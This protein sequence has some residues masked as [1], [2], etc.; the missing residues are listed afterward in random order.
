MKSFQR[1]F[2][3]QFSAVL[4][5]VLFCGMAFVSLSNVSAAGR[6]VLRHTDSLE[7]AKEP[8][9]EKRKEIN[10]K[11]LKAI[12]GTHALYA[13]RVTNSP[14]VDGDIYDEVYKTAP[15]T[16]LSF[17]EERSPGYPRCHTHVYAVCDKENLYLGFECREIRQHLKNRHIE[18]DDPRILKYSFAGVVLDLG[19]RSGPRYFIVLTTPFGQTYTAAAASNARTWDVSWQP[20]GLKAAT[21]HYVDRWLAE[22]CIPLTGDL[23]D[24]PAIIGA[25]YFRKRQCGKPQKAMRYYNYFHAARPLLPAGDD[26]REDEVFPGIPFLNPMIFENAD[27]PFFCPLFLSSGKKDAGLMKRIRTASATLDTQ[28]EY[29]AAHVPD[30]FALSRK[31]LESVFGDPAFLVPRIEKAPRIDGKGDDAA[32][33]KGKGLRLR[34]LLEEVPGVEE[35]NPT[36]VKIVSDKTHLYLYAHCAEE[37][38]DKLHMNPKE[39]MWRHDT[40]E[41]LFDVGHLEDYRNYYHIM[42]NP[43]GKCVLEKDRCDQRWNPESFTLASQINKDSWSVECKIAFKDLGIQTDCFPKLWGANFS[44]TRWVHRPEWNNPAEP[45]WDTAWK[46]NSHTVLHVPDRWGHLYFQAG[47]AVQPR[48]QRVLNEKGLD[49]KT[50]GF[51]PYRFTEPEIKTPR[52]SP[53]RKAAFADRPD[54]SIKGESAAISFG[55]KA[56]VDVTVHILDSQNRV[57]RHLACGKLGKNAPAPLQSDTLTQTLQWDMKDDM[58]ENV[59]KG[60]YTVRVGLGMDV[61]F[62][63]VLEWNPYS[64]SGIQGIA[65][66]P[67]GTLYV[68]T[69]R[70]FGEGW[71]TY[72]VTAF[73]RSGKYVR[74]IY[75]FPGNQPLKKVKGACPI[76]L[77]GGNWMATLY[78]NMSHMLIPWTFAFETQAPVVTGDGRLIL[79]SS[80]SRQCRTAKRLLALGTDGSIPEDFAGPAV[81]SEQVPGKACMAVSSDNNYYYVTGLRGLNLWPARGGEPHHAVYRR[82]WCAAPPGPGQRFVQ[83][84]I[85]EF[86]HRGSGKKLLNNPLGIDVDSDGNIYVADSGNNRIAVFRPDGTYLKELNVV[87][88]V[89]VQVHPKT[90]DV[91]VLSTRVK[92]IPHKAKKKDKKKRTSV[93]VKFKNK[94]TVPAAELE[95]AYT[96]L[97]IL[98]L[99][100]SSEQPAIWVAYGNRLLRFRDQDVSLVSDGDV[101]QRYRATYPKHRL[102]QKLFKGYRSL[103]P[104]KGFEGPDKHYYVFN[105][106]QIFRFNPAG[107]PAKFK[108][109][110]RHVVT[111]DITSKVTG[112]WPYYHVNRKGEIVIQDVAKGRCVSAWNLDGKKIKHRFITGVV[113]QGFHKIRSDSLGAVYMGSSIRPWDSTIPELL[114]GRIPCKFYTAANPRSKGIPEGF[115]AKPRY[116][117]EHCIGSIVKFPAK[118]GCIQTHKGKKWMLGLGH[119][120]LTPVSIEGMEW[121]RYDYGPRVYR[122]TENCNCNCE[123]GTFDIDLSDRLFIPNAS[124]FHVSVVDRN[125]N[126]IVQF[127]GYGNADEYGDKTSAAADGLAFAWP[128]CVRVNDTAVQV[129]DQVLNRTVQARITYMK[130]EE[131]TLTVGDK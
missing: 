98:V 12:L 118:G 128:L 19:K 130:K 84:F 14:N 112:Q 57:I 91:Y 35:R 129:Q 40:M 43:K 66:G 96:S 89:S 108:V 25:N 34:Y 4:S 90:S 49:L 17:L 67:D 42:I 31:D 100:H 69:G 7:S 71:C 101:M 99:D 27:A 56:P 131:C 29:G 103:G 68:I 58:G 47:N 18:T 24:S 119:S 2:S 114:Q 64:L 105:G 102:P 75:P 115:N 32:W 88:P 120:G 48:V 41:L 5:L 109:N 79:I 117:Y 65:T 72:S 50:P 92:T 104:D 46:P 30:G 38:V 81:A 22:L 95:I 51:K 83:P 15:V 8:A 62:D 52:P 44:R 45:N 21:V 121:M 11:G 77:P 33:R 20:K 123:C 3:F 53:V 111:T 106:K 125:N 37:A 94:K 23:S 10:L 85:G 113:P 9:G 107:K 73:D 124:M 13:P 127:G 70:G 16:H 97:G 80:G 78:Q 55:V 110:A 86:Q 1:G 59:P 74:Q 26:R 6:R 93:L 122:D 39:P 54:V 36:D 87:C 126:L 63:R 61:V 28:T 116:H 82:T 60:T 76:I